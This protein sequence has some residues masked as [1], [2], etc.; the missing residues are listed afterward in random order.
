MPSSIVVISPSLI[1][2]SVIH[3]FIPSFTEL[4]YHTLSVTLFLLY[5]SLSLI[6][7]TKNFPFLVLLPVRMHLFRLLSVA[8]V[9]AGMA[10]SPAGQRFGHYEVDERVANELMEFTR[11]LDHLE[12]RISEDFSL[13][14]QWNNDNL[15]NGNIIVPGTPTKVTNLNLKCIECY[16]KGKVTAKLTTKKL[17]KPIVRFDLAGVEAY[18]KLG[19]TTTGVL[20]FSVNLYSSNTPIGLSVRGLKL[21]IIF[22][23]DLAFT[24]S[25]A[26]DLEGGFYMKLAEDAFF[27]VDILDGDIMKNML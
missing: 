19:V 27:E 11:S 18:M 24:V 26:M 5:T 6:P 2:Y 20:A 9:A 21:G 4:P 1:A 15:F 13:D 17:I 10:V 3:S 25:S 7:L 22:S 23:V 8:T 12:K 14:K 16:T